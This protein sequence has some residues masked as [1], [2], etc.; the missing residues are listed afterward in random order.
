M[1]G[2]IF[3]GYNGQVLL[4]ANERRPGIL[5]GSLQGTRQSLPAKN[6]VAQNVTSAQGEKPCLKPT[7]SLSITFPGHL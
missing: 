4:P 6:S 5:L 2:G 1:P 3:C 7:G